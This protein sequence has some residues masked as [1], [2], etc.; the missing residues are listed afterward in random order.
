MLWNL[1]LCIAPYL[2]IHSYDQ[3]LLLDKIDI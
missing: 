2:K 1:I 3:L